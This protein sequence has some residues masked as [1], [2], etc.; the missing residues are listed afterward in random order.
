MDATTP[1]EI[2]DDLSFDNPPPRM[3]NPV[4]INT[5]FENFFPDSDS[6]C[7]P[8]GDPKQEG[9]RFCCEPI[10]NKELRVGGRYCQ[11]HYQVSF[12]GAKRV[13]EKVSDTKQPPRLDLVEGNDSETNTKN[14]GGCE[15]GS[16]ERAA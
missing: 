9:F 6:C 1:I 7:F 15:N 3:I 12:P 11:H 10:W 16:L 5:E 4:P 14:D 8:I 2:L 13:R